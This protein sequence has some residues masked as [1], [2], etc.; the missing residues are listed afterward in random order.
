MK[1]K[2][3]ETHQKG[4]WKGSSEVAIFSEMKT[5]MKSQ[6]TEIRQF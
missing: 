4:C 3:G 5:F 1:K 2:E 6:G